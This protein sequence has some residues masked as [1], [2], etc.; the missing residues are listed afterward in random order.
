MWI[1]LSGN[2]P[3]GQQQRGSSFISS[4]GDASQYTRK[5]VDNKIYKEKIEKERELLRG[6]GEIN[7]TENMRSPG[8]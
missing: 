5:K 6:E 4:D 3:I 8:I 7:R 1:S 2:T